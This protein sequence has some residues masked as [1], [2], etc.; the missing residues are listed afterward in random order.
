L[1]SWRFRST[2]H[3]DFTKENTLKT[4]KEIRANKMS[5]TN[6]RI[7]GPEAKSISQSYPELYKALKTLGIKPKQCTYIG[8]EQGAILIS[9]PD[10]MKAWVVPK[11]LLSNE[12]LKEIIKP[13]RYSITKLPSTKVKA[14]KGTEDVEDFG[15]S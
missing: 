3:I 7:Y 12:D 10:Q 9:C 11:E 6:Y 14:N 5:K 2:A 13:I 4:L 1:I 8:W 15:I